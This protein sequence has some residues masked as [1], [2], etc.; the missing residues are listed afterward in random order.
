MSQPNLTA[1]D[2][3]FVLLI[4]KTAISLSDRSFEEAAKPAQ[5][6]GIPRGSIVCPSHGGIPGE[7][8]QANDHGEAEWQAPSRVGLKPLRNLTENDCW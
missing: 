2:T 3:T 4:M 8:Q 6:L 5:R 7:P 1:G